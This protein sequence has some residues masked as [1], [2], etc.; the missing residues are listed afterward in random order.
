M[1]VRLN[2]REQLLD[3]NAVRLGFVEHSKIPVRL[4]WR[5][6]IGTSAGWDFC[7]SAGSGM[8]ISSTP[9]LRLACISSFFTPGSSAVMID[10][11]EVAAMTDDLLYFCVCSPL[12]IDL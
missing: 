11:S 8:R 9:L 6:E 5:Y 2:R 4:D 3:G 12:R 7:D 10:C 1:R